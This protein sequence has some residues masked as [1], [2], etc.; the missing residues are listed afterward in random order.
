LKAREEYNEFKHK[1]DISRVK[2]VNSLERLNAVAAQLEQFD[3]E[4]KQA[5]EEYNITI[6][7][8]IKV[9]DELAL[10]LAELKLI[11]IDNKIDYTTKYTALDDR[12]IKLQNKQTII[13]SKKAQI[14]AEERRLQS[15]LKNLLDKNQP[16]YACKRP[17]DVEHDCEDLIQEARNEISN[18]SY[19]DI[20]TDLSKIEKDI[21]ITQTAISTLRIQE[22]DHNTKINTHTNNISLIESKIS[23]LSELIE[24]TRSLISKKESCT[25]SSLLMLHEQAQN[26]LLLTQQEVG[27]DEEQLQILDSVK[28]ILSEEGVKSFL[29][30]K[31]LK[32]LNQKIAYYLTCL[33]APVKCEFNEFFEEKIMDEK[34]NEKSYFNFSGGERKRIDLA[35][36]FAFMDMKRLQGETIFNTTFYDELLDSSLDEKGV[37]LVLDVLRNRNKNFNEGC[38]IITHRGQHVLNKVDCIITLEKRNGFTYISK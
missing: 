3:N 17:F 14:C 37:D 19:Q 6:A 31:I 25:N 8:R 9:K 16:C 4:K 30:R 11:A 38:Y 28:Y 20:D 7:N 35:C 26:N 24:D 36:L 10:K 32:V 23:T 13:A 2:N 27:D 33:E 18:I 29:I 5:V 1:Y 12:V 34:N 22:R 15:Q 21:T